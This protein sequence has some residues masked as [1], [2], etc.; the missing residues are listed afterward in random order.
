MQ[1]L[2]RTAGRGQ[3]PAC[4]EASDG[5]IAFGDLYDEFRGPALLKENYTIRRKQTLGPGRPSTTSCEVSM[6]EL[7]VKGSKMVLGM[8]GRPAGCDRCRLRALSLMQLKFGLG[9]TGMSR[10]VSWG[11]YIASSPFW[12]VWPPE[13]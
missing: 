1:L 13:A 7:A 5:A 4:V 10:D 3:M 11:F 2:R 12:S 9:I 6:L 8:D